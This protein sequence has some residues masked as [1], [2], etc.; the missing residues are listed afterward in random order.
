MSCGGGVPTWMSIK[1]K[2]LER[3]HF[4]FL[5]ECQTEHMSLFLKN[6]P[7]SLIWQHRTLF[8]RPLPSSSHGRAEKRSDS[9]YK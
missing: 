3:S 9:N 1:V 8:S 6:I 5:L 4:F 7:L 2:I